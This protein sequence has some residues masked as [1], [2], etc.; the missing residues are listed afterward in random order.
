MHIER[1]ALDSDSPLVRACHEILVAALAADDPGLPA[2]TRTV[3]D[4][5]LKTGW[6]GEP[7]E[8][9]LPAGGQDP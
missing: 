4:G 8:T 1:L 3:F 9:W 2:M 6:S 5:W 7:R